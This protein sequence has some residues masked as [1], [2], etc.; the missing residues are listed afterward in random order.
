MKKPLASEMAWCE[1]TL[2]KCESP[3]DERHHPQRKGNEALMNYSDVGKRDFQMEGKESVQ[4]E[5][6]CHTESQEVLLQT[7]VSG[8]SRAGGRGR[9]HWSGCLSLSHH[10]R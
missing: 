6:L 7:G 8:C 9:L 3:E 10:P 5:G 4:A 1:G 2:K